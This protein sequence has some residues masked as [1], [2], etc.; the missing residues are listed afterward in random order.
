M[1]EYHRSFV[2]GGTYFFTIVTYHRLPILTTAE[3][4]QLL[5]SAWIDTRDRFSGKPRRSLQSIA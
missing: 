5:R 4:R 1:P 3:G 2:A